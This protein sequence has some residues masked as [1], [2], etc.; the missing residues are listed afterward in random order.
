MS[1]PTSGDFT[2]TAGWMDWY[3]AADK[4]G[5]TAPASLVAG[6]CDGM[7]IVLA[8]SVGNYGP[9]SCS[10]VVPADAFDIL[11]VGSVTSEGYLDDNSSR[12]PTHDGRIKPEVIDRAVARIR[13]D[14]PDASALMLVGHEPDL[15]QLASQWCTGADQLVIDLKKA[16]LVRLTASPLGVGRCAVLDWVLAPRLLERIGAAGKA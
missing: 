10:M 16:G 1:K 14:H 11:A 9:V 5:L 4:D 7:G 13:A 12:G 2:K 6:A 15:G 3:T 8:E